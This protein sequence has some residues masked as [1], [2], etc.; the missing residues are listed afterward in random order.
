MY[1]LIIESM[2]GLQV[3]GDR[4]RITPLLPSDW[5]SFKLDYRYRETDHHITV[6]RTLN[7]DA[8]SQLSLD[9]KVQVAQ[10]ITLID[11]GIDHSIE[12]RCR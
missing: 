11:D 4:L 3:Q 2:L 9:G 7:A 1:R 5:Q 8:D 12:L 10:H 6:L